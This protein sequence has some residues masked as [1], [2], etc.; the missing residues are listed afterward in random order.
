MK[1]TP[2]SLASFVPPLRREEDNSGVCS[3]DR[4][5]WRSVGLAHVSV[6]VYTC[7]H[8][9]MAERWTPAIP[10]AFRGLLDPCFLHRILYSLSSHL[11]PSLSLSFSLRPPQIFLSFPLSSSRVSTS[12]SS[13]ASSDTGFLG[14][15]A[16]SWW[17]STVVRCTLLPSFRR[18]SSYQRFSRSPLLVS[19]FSLRYPIRLWSPVFHSADPHPPGCRLAS[20]HAIVYR[21]SPS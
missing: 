11:P 2:V 7:N 15:L 3:P 5:G 6:M 12:P 18:R 20:T 13:S 16:D 19:R 1:C 9:R 14:C 8:Y 21:I 4:R 10:L 17:L